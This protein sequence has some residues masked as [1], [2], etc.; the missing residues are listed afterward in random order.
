MTPEELAN[1]HWTFIQKLLEAGGMDNKQ[2]NL[3]RIL[4]TESFI[5]GYKHCEEGD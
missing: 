1:E 2:L 3:C 5:H 4:Y